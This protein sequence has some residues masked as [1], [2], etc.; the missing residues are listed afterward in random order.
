MQSVGIFYGSS[1]GNTESAA[2]L[3]QEALGKENVQ[4]FDVANTSSDETANYNNLIFGASTWGLGDMQE[5]FEEFL[6]DLSNENL[7][8]KK[9][10]LYGYGD[11]E[12]YPDTFVDAIGDIYNELVD[13]GCE[14]IGFVS[15]DGYEYDESKAEIEGQFAGLA[16]DEENQSGLT[17]DRIIEWTGKLKEQFV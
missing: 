17:N 15:T 13:K 10:A 9:I 11:Q 4:I 2:K 12:T 14:I 6:S 5:D 8:G 3:I 7:E 1:T 16:L